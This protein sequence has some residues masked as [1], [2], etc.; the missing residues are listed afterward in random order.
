MRTFTVRNAGTQTLTLGSSI[1]V[2]TGF[3][4]VNGLGAISLAPGATTTFTVSLDATNAG[5][6]SGQVSFTNNDSDESPFNFT[7]SGTVSALSPEI[8]VLDGSTNV[9]DGTGSVS[10]GSSPVG[11]PVTRTF[12]VRNTGTQTLTL[13]SSL[14]LPSGFTLVNGFGSTSLAPGASTTFVVRFDATTAGTF[15]G[16][17]SF[18]SNDADES[19]FNFAVS[20]S[21]TVPSSVQILDDGGAGFSTS[22]SGWSVATNQ[23]H[24]SDV[25][26]SEAGNGSDTATWTFTVA[27]GRY[28]V[29]ATWTPYFNR[30]TNSPYTVLDGA[31][32][33]GT[34][35]LNQEPPPNDFTDGGTPWEDIGT[36][37]VAGTTLVVRLTDDANE[38]VIADAVRI[39]RVG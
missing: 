27:P 13:G 38:Y 26:Y 25:R 21:A 39:E 34:V 28:R 6:Y 30:A 8:E 3:T 14:S 23:G 20:G 36:F 5:I 10:F 9:V 16:Q 35:R 33:L 32:P 12:T 31:T 1:S 2:P 37:D 17:V 15:S 18:A 24:Q 4:L 22:G 11:T 19:P 29:S 7:V